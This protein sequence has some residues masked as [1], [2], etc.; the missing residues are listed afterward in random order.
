MRHHIRKPFFIECSRY[1]PQRP[2]ILKSIVRN[3]TAGCV[4][5]RAARTSI[6][7]SCFLSVNAI[8]RGLGS[9]KLPTDARSLLPQG[10]F[11]AFWVR[12]GLSG[13][14]LS[15]RAAGSRQAVCR[16]ADSRGQER[17]KNALPSILRPVPPEGAGGQLGRLRQPPSFPRV[18]LRRMRMREPSPRSHPR[19]ALSFTEAFWGCALCRKLPLEMLV[20]H[21]HHQFLVQHFLLLKML[22]NRGNMGRKM[23]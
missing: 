23:E 3:F 7:A 5:Q 18:V 4:C 8:L 14:P 15:P 20:T 9:S 1:L 6:L 10:V 22:F 11:A 13:T 19:C 17:S 16:R 2:Q 12:A 21:L